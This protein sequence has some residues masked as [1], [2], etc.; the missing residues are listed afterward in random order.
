M[1]TLLDVCIDHAPK[2]LLENKN[3]IDFPFPVR[4]FKKDRKDD[5]S[6]K[7]SF[8]T[9]QTRDISVQ[10]NYR[11]WLREC[12]DMSLPII[13]K[14]ITQPIIDIESISYLD[15]ASQAKANPVSPNSKGNSVISAHTIPSIKDMIDA[16]LN[17]KRQK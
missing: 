9:N 5:A 12:C 7:G 17:K 2:E 8:L 16:T 13:E 3:F 10:D 14:E 6:M 11:T 4:L 15:A 1:D